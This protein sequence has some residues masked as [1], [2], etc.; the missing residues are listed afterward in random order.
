MRVGHLELGPGF[1]LAPMEAGHRSAVPDGLRGARGEPDL[2]RVPVGRCT[3]SRG[4]K[5]P[6]THVAKPGRPPLRGA[7]S[8]AASPRFWPERRPM[9]AEVGATVVDINMG[10]PAKKVTAGWCGSALMREPALAVS[11]V[12][13]VRAVLTR[14]HPGHG[15]AP[16]WLGRRL[17][18]RADFAPPDGRSGSGDD[19]PGPRPYPALRA[20]PA[21]VRLAPIAAVRAALPPEIP[22]WANGD[23]KTPADVARNERRRLAATGV[24]GRGCDGQPL[25]LPHLQPSPTAPRPGPAELE[26]ATRHSGAVTPGLVGQYA[27]PRM[28]V[29][30]LHQRPCVVLAA[31]CAEARSCASARAPRRT[32]PLCSRSVR[33]TSRRAAAPPSGIRGWTDR[34]ATT[35][36]AVLRGRRT[37]SRRARPGEG[38]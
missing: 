33:L 30:E 16:R 18:K 5:D 15:Q 28:L 24:I 12:R 26:E 27:V 3:H 38:A 34:L 1:L 36:A 4:G 25:D 14:G 17:D 8:S 20:S 2:H 37:L 9:A 6:G 7:D 21:A 19:S 11:L 23:V 29:H 13:A 22:W 32:P 35:L 10:C 31:A